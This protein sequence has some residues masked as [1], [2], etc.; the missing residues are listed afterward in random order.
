MPGAFAYNYRWGRAIIRAVND[1]ELVLI[2]SPE[3]D[4]DVMPT[5]LDRV[6][7][8]ITSREGVVDGMDQWGKRKLAYPLDGFVEGNYIVTRCK[9]EPR[10][11]SEVEA[12]IKDMDAVLR[13]LAVKVED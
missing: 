1:Y 3:V 5:V 13:H 10:H 11:L 8:S 2:V 7:Q 9:L 12:D 6:S 4:G